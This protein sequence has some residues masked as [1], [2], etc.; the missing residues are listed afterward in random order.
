MR[1]PQRM[2]RW[3]ASSRVVFDTP[4]IVPIRN[5]LALLLLYWYNSTY[6]DRLSAPQLVRTQDES[7]GG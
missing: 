6:T 3:A 7:L 5:L 1:L 4:G 2:P